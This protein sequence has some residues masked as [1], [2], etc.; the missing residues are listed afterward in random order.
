M[1]EYEIKKRE[2]SLGNKMREK[3]NL[4]NTIEFKVEKIT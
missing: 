3:E 2:R 1:E 4:N